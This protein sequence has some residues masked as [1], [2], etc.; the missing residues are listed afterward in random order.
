MK[1]RSINIFWGIVLIGMGV[2]FFLLEGG[3]VDFENFS[4]LTWSLIFGVSGL[5]FLITYF[6]NGMDKWT[7]LFPAL[8]S[9]GVSVTIGLQNT[10]IGNI[11]S[12][13]PILACIAAPF[14]VAYTID[15]EKKKWALIP[16]WAMIVLAGVVLFERYL[17]GNLLAMIIL[18]NI[19]LP[20]L[21]VYIFDRSRKWALIPFATIS[22]VSI[23]PLMEEILPSSSFEI[24]LMVV[25]AIPFIVV[26]LYSRKNWWALIPAG[27]F[28][29]IG[30][31]LTAEHFGLKESIIGAIIIAG[32]GLTFGLLWVLRKEHQTD[33]AKY[34]AA[35]LLAVTP[36]ILVIGD[37]TSIIGPAVLVAVG[38]A[39][40][41]YSLMQRKKIPSE[42]KE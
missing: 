17:G 2:L 29:S 39:V 16:A 34:P 36:L 10:S 20:F 31:A 21:L 42:K 32:F 6:I 30:L 37:R 4:N 13:A 14:L 1:T 38:L 7:W 28:A 22:V 3:M 8:G 18:F 9:I 26:Y 5:F 19:A 35:G 11:L 41:I 33:W 24:V 23:I 12:G 15:P 27:V 40:I 25:F